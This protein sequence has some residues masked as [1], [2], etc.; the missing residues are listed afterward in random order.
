MIEH[1]NVVSLWQSLEHIYRRAP[2]CRRIAINAS[3]NFDAS[4]KQF[5]QL[6]SGRALVLIPEEL[7]WDVAALLNF[8]DSNDV[9]GIDCTPSQLRS[10]IS[11][12]MLERAR[13]PLRVVLV[14]G[15]PIDPELWRRLAHCDSIEFY[16]IYGPTECTVDATVARLR[17]DTSAPHIGPPMENKRVYLL[18]RH[19]QPVPVGVCGEICIG[20]AGVGRGYLNRPE[21]TAQRFIT[22]SFSADRHARMYTTGDLGQWREDGTI[23]YLGRNDG[24]VKIRG[25]R[26]ELG[27]IEALLVK[28][29]RVR[30]AAVV[31]REDTPGDKCLVAYVTPREQ[32]GPS[33]AELRAHLGAA[34]PEHMIPSAFVVLEVLPLTPSGKLDH[35]AL[36]LPELDAYVSRSYEAPRGEVEVTLA[37]IWQDLLHLERVGRHDHFFDLGGHSLLAMQVIV[38]IRSLLLTTIPISAL[39]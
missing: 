3:F 4:V 35:R 32:D 10:W 12:G 28:H 19:R 30:E 15:E 38:R 29:E 11:A 13:C 7:R 5:V 16:N 39:F 20:G 36:P 26:I 21:L 23:E 31:A 2:E 18:N 17:H 22:D 33:A 37:G 25:Y 6:L 1:R 24:Q 9:H 27:E 14:G 8:L 34:L